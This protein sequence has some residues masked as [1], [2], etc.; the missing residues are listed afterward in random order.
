V[1]CRFRGPENLEKSLYLRRPSEFFGAVFC[2]RF[3]ST[4]STTLPHDVCDPRNFVTD[5]LQKCKILT[6][7]PKKFEGSKSKILSW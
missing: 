6:F 2:I 5:L 3:R 4:R 7:D 1:I